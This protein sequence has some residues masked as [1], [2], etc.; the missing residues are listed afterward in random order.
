M[1]NIN[2]YFGN[3]SVCINKKNIE[4]WINLQEN[5]NENK[6]DQNSIV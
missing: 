2:I 5:G 6:E 1:I 3:I 4:Y